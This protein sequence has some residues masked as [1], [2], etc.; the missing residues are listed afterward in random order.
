[1]MWPHGY[2]I[3]SLPFKDND[4]RGKI[5][6]VLNSANHIITVSHSNLECIK[7]LNVCTPVT[8]IPNGFKNNLFYPRN[9]L[10]CRKALKLPLDKKIILTVGNLEPIKGQ[11]YLI[12]AV[13]KII[14]V[15]KEVLCIFVGAGKLRT[16]LE[17]QVRSLGLDEHGPPYLILY[18]YKCLFLYYQSTF[19]QPSLVIT[20]LD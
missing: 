7:K 5:E 10:E 19:H 14:G 11:Q 17:R 4:W 9:V 18:R 20:L 12:E 15:K 6:S 1:M 2:D 16:A 3:Y 13:H 8:I